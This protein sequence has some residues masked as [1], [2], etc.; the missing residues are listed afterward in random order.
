MRLTLDPTDIKDYRRF[1]AVKRLPRYAVAGETVEFPDEYAG[2]LGMRAPNRP[3]LAYRPSPFLFDYQRDIAA[4]ALGKEK[5]GCFAEPGRGKTL[6]A[7]EYMRTVAAALPR[8]RC[9]LMVAPLNVVSQT[10]DEFAK[11]YGDS[12]PVEQVRAA[13]LNSWLE[14]GSSRIGITNYEALT[15]DVRPGRLAALVPDEASL[16]KSHYGKWGGRLVELGKGL[17]W[18]LTLTGTPAPNDR[19]E[20]A[21]QAVFLDQFPT[22]NA[23]LARYFVNRG[24]TDNRWEL[25]PH[26][27]R[28]FYRSLS[29]W[30]I[31]LSNP[32]VYGWEDGA[33]PLPPI[34]SH[35][36]DVP[37][38]EE[39]KALVVTAGGDMYGTP[40]GITSRAKLAQLAK[41]RHEGADVPSNKPGFIR[42]LVASWSDESTLIWCR[43]NAEQQG[44][45]RLFPDAA[46][47]DGSTPQEDRERLIRD[48]KEGRRKVLISK[49]KILGF[50]L[51]LQVATRQVFSTCQDSYEEYFQCVKRSNRIGSTR[52]LNV[53]IPV[54]SIERPM[55]DTV[56]RK[57]GEV[58]RDTEEQERIFKECR[59]C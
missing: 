17:R 31:F 19:I 54:T 18:K 38:T 43:Y 53:H 49:P 29:H 27:L 4:L 10:L 37:L 59:P 50:G 21:Q 24:Q 12:L 56:L 45:A 1:L 55:V 48:F 13:Q 25:K 32:G 9:V 39:Q 15:D 51:N 3:A 22:V 26:A 52:P 58:Q 28:P 36:H 42:R 14:S 44:I 23:F 5:F 30:C 2:V 46:N 57:A 33:E 7:G 34:V 20:Y 40:G 47:I 6:I 35:I 41:G 8:K 11:F 16:M